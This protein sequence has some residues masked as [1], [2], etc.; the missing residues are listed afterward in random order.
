MILALDSSLTAGTSACGLSLS[1]G[2]RPDHRRV[3]DLNQA[4][5][6]DLGQLR[7]DLFDLLRGFDEL[8][9]DGHLV[10][11]FDQS[12]GVELVVSA[13]AGHAAG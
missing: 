13:E 11:N 10:R 3:V 8:D 6:G 5:G 9:L 1:S 4:M 2:G 7:Q 12:R